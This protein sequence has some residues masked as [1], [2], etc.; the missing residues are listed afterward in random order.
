MPTTIAIDPGRSGGLVW[1]D[2]ITNVAQCPMPD[3]VHDLRD[4]LDDILKDSHQPVAYVEKVGGYTGGTG[5]PGSAM[6]NF[7]KN[8]GEIMGLL[9]AARI[10]VEEVMPQKWQ[11]ALSLGTTAGRSKSQWKN[12]L[13]A[14]A[15]ALYPSHRITLKTSDAF[16][17]FHAAQKGLI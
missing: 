12:H 7:G 3:N 9:A 17:I 8:V 4:L 16:L 5:S 6:F 13:K 14:K 1:G 10:P 2:D 11:K 15:C